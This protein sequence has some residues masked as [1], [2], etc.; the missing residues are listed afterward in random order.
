[1]SASPRSA[2]PEVLARI[3]RLGLRANQAVQGSLTGTHKSPHVGQSVEFAD[4]REYAPGDDLRRLDW[5][6][7]ARTGRHVVKLYEEETNLR[8]SFLLDASA[9]MRYGEA[10]D[11]LGAAGDPK[12]S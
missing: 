11:A 8:A 9:A 3:A 10:T 5:R 4:F 1:M 12:L 2:S 6:V 7:Y